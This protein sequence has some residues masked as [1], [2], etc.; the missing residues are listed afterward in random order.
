MDKLNSGWT[1][2]E[3]WLNSDWTPTE[4]W[5][6]SGWI[7]D[8]DESDG[9]KLLLWGLPSLVN[10]HTWFPWYIL[11]YTSSSLLCH[12]DIERIQKYGEHA[13]VHHPVS[14][15]WQT[16]PIHQMSRWVSV[17][18]GSGIRFPAL[19]GALVKCLAIPS[20]CGDFQMCWVQIRLYKIGK[21]IIRSSHTVIKGSGVR[22]PAVTICRSLC[23][24]SHPTLP[25]CVVVKCD[26]EL[27]GV[28]PIH[29]D[30]RV[31]GSIPSSEH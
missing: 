12:C 1:P 13:C 28:W 16:D 9:I 20:L 2:A 17:I 23:K 30:W 18:K 8:N 3:F 31:Q 10:I 29:M 25:L 6:N 15:L 19:V 21:S 22:F 11:E 4:L 24:V 14:G 27:I 7:L 5:L 26:F